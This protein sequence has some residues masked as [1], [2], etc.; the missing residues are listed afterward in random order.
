MPQQE[1]FIGV[2]IN[3]EIL[4][5][6]LINYI[7]LNG[8]LHHVINLNHLNHD[9][10]SIAIYLT[11]S[12]DGLNLSTPFQVLIAPIKECNQICPPMSNNQSPI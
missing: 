5:I 9:W 7:D 10:N 1:N 4:A 12:T 3:R 8:L 6:H 2:F 11:I